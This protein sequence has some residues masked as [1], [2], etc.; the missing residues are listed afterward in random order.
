MSYEKV[1]SVVDAMVQSQHWLSEYCST[2]NPTTALSQHYVAEKYN[3]KTVNAN[4]YDVLTNDGKKIQVKARWW[5]KKVG[6]PSG[7]WVHGTE[8]EADLFVFVGFDKDYNIIYCMEFLP[9]ELQQYSTDIDK[10]KPGLKTI[11]ITK[12]LIAKKDT[13]A[14]MKNK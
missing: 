8:G 14:N 12:K 10:R 5:R 9:S 13:V 7:S 11:S 2:T 4:G 3:G 6:G 1:K